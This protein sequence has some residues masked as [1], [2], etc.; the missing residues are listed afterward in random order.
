MC[1][2]DSLEPKGGYVVKALPRTLRAKEDKEMVVLLQMRRQ[3]ALDLSRRQRSF[4]E[5]ARFTD[6]APRLA[7]GFNTFKEIGMCVLRDK[8]ADNGIDFHAQ[9]PF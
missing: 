8:V 7:Q 5:P 9:S 3:A 4:D 2:E 6:V 1:L